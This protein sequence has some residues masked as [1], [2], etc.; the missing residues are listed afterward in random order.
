LSRPA[1]AGVSPYRDLVPGHEIMEELGRGGMG[2]VYRAHQ[3]TPSRE[4]ALKML[5]PL[6]SGQAELRAR[7]QQEARAL[8]ELEHPAILPLYQVGEAEGLPYFTMK[9]AGG[10]TLAARLAVEGRWSARSSAELIALLA[11]ALHH[12][13]LHGVIHRDLKPGNIL[14]DEAGRPYLADFGLAKLEDALA[15]FSRSAG[16]LGTPAYL[17]P[18]IASFGA[19][20]AT[21][22]SDVYGLGAVLYE[23]L[24]GRP[25]FVVEGLA[26]LLRL[27]AEEAPTAPSTLN[28]RV[29]RDLEIICLKCLR[30]APS[31]RYASAAEFAGDLRRWLRGEP[32]RARRFTFAERLVKWA[33]RRPALASLSAALMLTAAGS[34]AWLTRSNRQLNLALDRAEA[35]RALAAQRA[36]FVVWKVADQ[37]EDLGRLDILNET[38]EDVLRTEDGVDDASRRRRTLILTRWGR[39]L[40][41][42]NRHAEARAPLI[43]AVQLASALPPIGAHHDLH[44]DASAALAVLTAET[45]SFEDAVALLAAAGARLE[46]TRWLAPVAREKALAKLAE[47]YTEIGLSTVRSSKE[48]QQQAARA[49]AHRRTA[50]AMEPGDD[51][52]LALAVSLRI[53]GDTVVREARAETWKKR[54]AEARRAWQAA[55]PRF[56]E[57]LGLTLQRVARERISPAWERE[58]AQNIGWLAEVRAA[59]DPAYLDQALELLKQERELLARVVGRDPR[60][61]RSQ[62]ELASALDRLAEQYK[63]RSDTALEDATRT[64]HAT[65]IRNIQDLAPAARSWLL[66]GL[67]ANLALGQWCLSRHQLDEAEAHFRDACES[68]ETLVDM[69]PTHRSDQRGLMNL[70]EGVEKAWSEV[71]RRDKQREVLERALKYAQGQAATGPAPHAFSWIAAHYH[72]RLAD[73]WKEEGD[74]HASLDHNLAALNGRAGVLRAGATPAQVDPN[75]VPSSYLAAETTYIAL[76]R[77]PEAVDLALQAL[78]LRR[79]VAHVAMDPNPWASAIVKAAAKG[80]DAGGETEGNA[81]RL[82]SRALADLYAPDQDPATPSLALYQPKP[83]HAEAFHRESARL[84]TALK[85]LAG[86]VA[87]PAP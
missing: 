62:R 35:A 72:R 67:N 40:F 32:I 1:E 70:A 59:L 21:T 43:E 51:A 38:Y 46:N 47:A 87:A 15:S 29:P 84:Q 85:D 53:E 79:S 28:A 55:L 58:E 61:W 65:V 33:R 8:A 16:V 45:G 11:D 27:I 10:G 18:E 50:L 37:L 3:L 74:L 41:L 31:D 69:R 20:S 78:D 30:K 5:L 49:V 54:S 7:F 76:D 52:Q 75:A 6:D 23:L 57:A 39:N 64:E 26:A 60:N 73:W 2:V 68:A 71:G 48:I 14:F 4:V 44:A 81:R 66:V 82:A 9:L 34:G 36:E 56:E 86:S 12:A 24:T 77:V 83:E 80:V 13:H 25:P 42:Q 17:A 63:K 19:R 22:V